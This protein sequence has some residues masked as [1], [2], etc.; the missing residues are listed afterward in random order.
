MVEVVKRAKVTE[1]VTEQ[2]DKG[3][4]SVSAAAS[5]MQDRKTEDTVLNEE[6]DS[7]AW[8]IDDDG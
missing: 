4:F 7:S 2:F 1:V 5:N 6:F 3:A 8:K